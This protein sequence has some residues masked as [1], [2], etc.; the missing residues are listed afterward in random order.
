MRNILL[1]MALLTALASS[2][3]AQTYDPL[4]PPN[5]FRNSDNPNYWKNRP[6]YE[7]YFQQDVHYEIA[8]AIDEKTDIITG[9]MELIYW[10]NSRDD[11]EFVYFHLYQNAFQPG[12]Y[13][14]NLQH[15][16]NVD[17]IYG[18]YE[19]EKL[20]TTIEKLRVNEKEVKTEL[21]NTI[22]KVYLPNTL[23]SGESIKINLDFKTYFDFGR[24]RRRMKVFYSWGNN[25]ENGYKHYDGVHWYPRIS[26]YDNKFGWTTDQHL[27]HEFYGDF[28]TF[29]VE[30]TF[31]SNYVVEATGFLQNRDQ[32][33]PKDLRAKLDIKNFADKPWN[34]A[35]S[36]I[37]PYNPKETKTWKY[38]AENVH[39]FAFTADPTYRIG[40]AEWKGKKAISLAQEMH[41]SK[42]QNAASYTADIVKVYSED[43]G[44]YVYHKIIVAD[45][46]DGM[47]YPM[48]T[49]DGG[50]EPGY[51]GLLAH[52]VGHNWFFGQVG[53]NESYR[54]FM[55]EGFTQFLTT[56]SLEK[57]DG[58]YQVKSPPRSGYVKRFSKPE[59][60]RER[61]LYRTYI[62]DAAKQSSTTLNTH[63][64]GFNG[65][66]RH[67][68]GYRQ[69]YYK[70]AA[71]L[72]N[73]QYVLGEELFSK[74]IKN[75]F[76]QWKICHPYPMDFRNS[77]IH[78]TDVDLNW[79]FD[80]WLETS[81]TIDYSVNSVKKTG[82]EGEYTITFERKKGM[83]M[84]I[85]FNVVTK[86]GKTYK[87]HIPNNWFV[88]TVDAKVLPKWHGW[89]KLHPT[90]E[91]TI[92]VDDKI[93]NVIIDPSHRMADANMLNNSKKFP[94]SVNFDSKLS[95]TTDWTK[96]EVFARPD[97][98]YNAYDGIKA[99]V[100]THGSYLKYKHLFEADLWFNT[101]FGQ[102]S[103]DAAVN[104]NDYDPLS[105]RFTYQTSMDKFSKGSNIYLAAKSLDGLKAY[106][107]GF[108]KTDETG[109]N[110]LYL[111]FQSLYRKR[112]ADLVYLLYPELWNSGMR[113]NF[114]NIGLQHLYRYKK[115]RG[116]IN[117]SI[118]S[119]AVGSDYDYAQFKFTA[120]NKNRLG[121]IDL[122]TRFITQIGSGVN[123]A[124]ESD[125]Y[126]AGANPEE[127]MENK[128]T[129]SEFATDD[130]WL[131]YGNTT[132]HF[133][134]GGGL[135]LRGYAGYYIAEPNSDDTLDIR[136]IF[137][138]TSGMAFNV[139]LEF[140]KIFG[141]HPVKLSKTLGFTSYLFTDLGMINSNSV[142]ESLVFSDVRV[143][144]GLGMMLTIKKWGVFEEIEPLNIR[145]DMPFFLNRTPSIDPDFVQFRWVLGINRAF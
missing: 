122:N 32:V 72:Y 54:A 93:K 145:F 97:F 108:D 96:Y 48:I 134:H 21:D 104:V 2:I 100:H 70:T 52:E 120:V 68:G 50:A 98:W 24:V 64:D 91:A 142:A 82:N 13:Y 19:R 42:W 28:G 45:A 25:L 31:S 29:D 74:A 118:R 86:S 27:G 129:R 84:P 51:R 65:A 34:E 77:F 71:M 1:T 59:K 69:V 55:D 113:N 125:L 116:D 107:V 14:D 20:G 12:S 33:L 53:N 11:L 101:G 87:Y 143:D 61:R 106:K 40:E 47:E 49:L 121:K 63:S 38:H 80:Q 60:V 7:G 23:K 46:R 78:Y 22:L 136:L 16:N 43:F 110:R 73:L 103:F 35:P 90:Y 126:A 75:Y 17:P 66:L 4:H 102:G 114:V 67:G 132:S 144:A 56:W 44:M 89:D 123:T 138:G 127:M 92:T 115:G 76:E 15:N 39:D 79:F 5:T 105:V 6:P 137:R 26:V 30:L 131:R 119:S 133:Q 8:A 85:D 112:A 109:N 18:K 117:I 83:Q 3:L 36:V 88:K 111:D 124:P 62:S 128:Y 139:E 95:R 99:G 135:N 94:L 57:I 41:A 58:P 37:T 141:W 10:N 130:E 81:K 9:S 140:Q